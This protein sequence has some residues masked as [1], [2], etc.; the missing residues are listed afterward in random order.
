V[1]A[2]ADEIGL[3][4]TQIGGIVEGAGVKVVD[5]AGAEIALGKGGWRHF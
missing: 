5:A 1:R 4:L 3:P 2:L